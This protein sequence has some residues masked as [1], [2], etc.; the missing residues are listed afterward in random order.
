MVA[1]DSTTDSQLSHGSP[2]STAFFKK[3]NVNWLKKLKQWKIDDPRHS[4]WIHQRRKR[5]Y[6]VDEEEEDGCSRL[7]SLRDIKTLS[8]RFSQSWSNHS[9]DDDEDCFCCSKEVTE[10][11]EEEFL[12]DENDNSSDDYSD[13]LRMLYDEDPSQSNESSSTTAKSPEK[14]TDEK[15]EED[16]NCPLC[17]NKMDATD[18]LFKPCSYCVYKICLFCYHKMIRENTGVCPG[19][20]RKYEKQTSGSKSGVVAFQQPGGDPIPL[21]SSFQGLDDSA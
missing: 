20:R 6:V 13:A 10:K 15:K 17:I 11:E 3:P 5:E 19:C 7:R 21:S 8:E 16:E 9:D 12:C 4:Q 14:P 1:A 2:I 18:L